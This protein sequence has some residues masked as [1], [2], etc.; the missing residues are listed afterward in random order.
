METITATPITTCEFCDEEFDEFD[1]LDHL[2]L[3]HPELM[4]DAA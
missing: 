1:I 4:D 3:A 2:D